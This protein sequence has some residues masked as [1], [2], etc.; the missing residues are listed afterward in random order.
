MDSPLVACGPGRLVPG[1]WNSK[2]ARLRC[3]ASLRAVLI[4]EDLRTRLAMTSPCCVED[5]SLGTA[6]LRFAGSDKAALRYLLS[7]PVG[8]SG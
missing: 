3:A 8:K 6:L 5:S 7:P 1:A 4:C 2:A